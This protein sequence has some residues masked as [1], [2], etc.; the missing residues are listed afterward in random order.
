MFRRLMS[1]TT[2][3][4]GLR[5]ASLATATTT[6]PA[7]STA[8]LPMAVYIH[9]NFHGGTFVTGSSSDYDGRDLT[10]FWGSN[11]TTAGLL[12]T[13]NYRL[14]D[15]GFPGAAELRSRDANA[16]ERRQ[17][18]RTGG[19]SLKTTPPSS[20]PS[21]RGF[22]CEL[23]LELIRTHIAQKPMLRVEAGARALRNPVGRGGG[24]A[25]NT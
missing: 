18:A 4:G 6:A 10:A 8:L 11:G 15:L 12:V 1:W 19:R 14:G 23:E 5:A 16:G 9:E 20:P 3:G 22:A 24:A 17:T 25:N 21:W 7:G 2:S 13:I